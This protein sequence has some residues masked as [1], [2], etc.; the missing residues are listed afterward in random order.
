MS[1]PA[2]TTDPRLEALLAENRTAIGELV[3]QAQK[4]PAE[5]WPQPLA[6]GGWSPAQHVAHVALAY[7]ALTRELETGEGMRLKGRRWQR[8]LFRT[9]FLPR[10]LRRSRIPSGA[11]APR[12]T[13]P[14]DDPG[15]L[16]SVIG[17]LEASVSEF[18]HALSAA[19]S[20]RPRTRLNHP[21]FGAVSLE[22]AARFVP[23]HTRH[24]ANLI[25]LAARED[26]GD[27]RAAP[28]PAP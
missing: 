9:V 26:G 20:E 6:P 4:V 3:G 28:L 8:W 27:D 22:R 2:S 25:E 17:Q 19:W 12:E 11:R 14:P 5:F 15:D 16:S 13:R 10:I 18:E 24:H 23:V 21:Y 7:Q 1:Q